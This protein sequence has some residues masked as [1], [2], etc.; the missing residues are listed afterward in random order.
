MDGVLRDRKSPN[1]IRR[2]YKHQRNFLV[3][4]EDNAVVVSPGVS[5]R[6]ENLHMVAGEISQTKEEIEGDSPLFSSP[7]RLECARSQLL[8]NN[9]TKEKG[10]Q[11]W[12]R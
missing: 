11:T 6:K 9:Y 12:D 8:R 1:F 3:L 2:L 4:P 5:S 10:K 7:E